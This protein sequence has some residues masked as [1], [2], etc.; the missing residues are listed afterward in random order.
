MNVKHQ[1]GSLRVAPFKAGK[2]PSVHSQSPTPTASPQG[3][4]QPTRD[5][6]HKR[7]DRLTT[8][9]LVER[10]DTIVLFAKLHRFNVFVTYLRRLV[11][12][13]DQDGAEP[14]CGDR[15]TA[16]MGRDLEGHLHVSLELSG[17]NAVEIKAIIDTEVD[18][19]YRA[20]QRESEAAGRPVPSTAVLR[21]RAVA[22][23]IRR[24]ADPNPA[25]HKPVASVILPVQVDRD[26]HP[27]ADT[28]H[29]WQRR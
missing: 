20:A 7:L 1:D 8:D 5:H 24:G 6:L 19:Q 3:S 18:R 10:E 16:A 23:L 13:I 26:G 11:A 15:D 12:I 4:N 17:H 2:Q 29:R 28:H 25:G 27:T 22:E 9:A 14:D 21:A